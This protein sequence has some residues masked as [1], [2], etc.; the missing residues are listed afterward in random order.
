[1]KA[2]V[3]HGPGQT[4]VYGDFAEPTP[5][6]GES[7]IK[8]AAA[9]LS[10]LARSRAMGAHYSSSG[11]YP[12]VAGFDGVGRLDDGKRVY[13]IQSRAPHGAFAEVTVAPSAS[14]LPLHQNLDDV[15]AAAIANPGMSSWVA[16]KE[17]AKL[18]AG[19]TVLINGAT[20]AAG[21]L[22]VQIAK[23]LGAKKV[24]ATGRNPDALSEVEALGADVTILLS[25][26]Q[27]ALEQ[28]FKTEF[29]E[30]VDV[31]LDYLWGKSAERLLI[32]AAKAAADAYPIRFV[33]IGS[34]SGQSITLPSAVLRSKAIELMGSGIGSVAPNRIFAAIGE[35]M[36]AAVPA[37]LKIAAQPTPLADV[38]T[39]WSSKGADRLVFI[40]AAHIG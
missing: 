35:L 5:S 3:V 7:R 29:A 11:A 1:M 21:R 15:T 28:R 24:I 16:F 12:A 23:H 32:A 14:C 34:M 19:E 22:A 2:A 20:G 37:G 25:A 18:E 39:A 36:Q 26:N 6:Q 13:F 31:V 30:G 40:P 10:Q 9:A 33:E 17:R 38:E 8:V 4:P 27:E